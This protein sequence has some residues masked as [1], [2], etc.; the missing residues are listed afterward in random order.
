M[1]ISNQLAETTIRI[2]AQLP[3]NI[4]STGSGFLFNI[5]QLEPRLK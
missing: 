4:V 5:Q 2:E 1:S 3:Q